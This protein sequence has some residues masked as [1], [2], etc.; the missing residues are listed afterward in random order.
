MCY[1][2]TDN[3]EQGLRQNREQFFWLVIINA[4][5]GGMVG[6]ERS[7]LPQIADDVFGIAAHS[8]IL[9]FIITFGISKAAA[10]Y[11]AG[12]L[13]NRYGRKAILIVSWLFAIPVPL[14][15]S[16]ANSWEWIVIANI[17]LGI[18]QGLAWSSTVMMKIDLV[19]EKQRGLAMGINEFSGYI[20]VAVVAFLT[21]YIAQINGLRPYPFLIGIGLIV[22][23]IAGSI[24]LVGDTLSFVKSE[25]KSST[26]ARL[27]SVFLDTT[28][29]HKI[30]GSVTQA[31]LINNMN[32]G[33]MWG[34]LPLILHYKNF[35]L[36][37][38]GIIT[39]IYPAVWGLGQLITGKLS[40]IFCKK[41]L[42]VW[43]MLLQ[44]LAIFCIPFASSLWH[45]YSI[46]AL[47]G[48]GTAM[49]YPTFMA[50]IAENTH[51]LDRASSIGVFRLWRDLGY[52]IG[53]ILTGI[54]AD[55][56]GIS[57]AVFTIAALT[58]S[59]GIIIRFRMPCDIGR[60]KRIFEIFK[61]RNL[62]T[63]SK[64]NKIN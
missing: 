21:G 12:R 14:L 45:F 59:S 23:G 19:G 1:Q 9:S 22:M 8:A 48:W 10:N 38:I 11:V 25:S 35:P 6:M 36:L 30:L 60:G 27:T 24:C 46:S 28:W 41:D 42:L 49:V 51:P 3:T 64:T 31:G 20:S 26:Q 4:F 62:F 33:M 61:I 63:T 37:Q 57:M 53:A 34:L 13:S 18:N 16:Y 29:R 5:V 52:A 2:I 44:G 17:F 43:G 15:L 7:I 39:A 50:S 58:L 40:D 56:F 54:I 47:L 55:T 32:D